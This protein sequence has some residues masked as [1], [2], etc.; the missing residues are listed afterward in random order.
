MRDFDL[1]DRIDYIHNNPVVQEIVRQPEDY[2]YSS[3][4]DFEGGKGKVK[5]EAI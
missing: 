4:L 5:I 3:A 2:I 1:N